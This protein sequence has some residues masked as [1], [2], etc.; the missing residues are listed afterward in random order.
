MP[1]KKKSTHFDLIFLN[2]ISRKSALISLAVAAF[3]NIFGFGIFDELSIDFIEAEISMQILF[4]DLFADIW[5]IA[6]LMQV[7]A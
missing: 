3:M 4:I 1:Q 5:R 6:L 2:E 7:Y